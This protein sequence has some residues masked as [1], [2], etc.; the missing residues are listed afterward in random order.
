LTVLLDTQ[1]VLWAL[2]APKRLG[3]GRELIADPRATRLISV[4]VIW[5]VAIK[6]GLGRL[7]LPMS[8]AEWAERARRDLDAISVAVSEPHAAA[9]ATLPHHH[10]DPF[11]RLLVAQARE[12][13]VPI[14]SADPALDAYDVEV[15]RIR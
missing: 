2:A 14:A 3:A 9:V 7:H 1:V 10:R 8:V 6:V 11:D 5:E 13:G 12:L 4:V 15:I